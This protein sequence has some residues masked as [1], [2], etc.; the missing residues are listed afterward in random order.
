LGGRS[1]CRT[2]NAA[3]SPAGYAVRW[4]R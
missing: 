4:P 2:G 3:T 1:Y